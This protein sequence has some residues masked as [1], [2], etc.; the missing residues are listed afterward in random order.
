MLENNAIYFSNKQFSGSIYENSISHILLVLT[1]ID[2]D[3]RVID[4]H[5]VDIGLVC[6]SAHNKTAII[7]HFWKGKRRIVIILE[8]IKIEQGNRD[9]TKIKLKI[10]PNINITNLCDQCDVYF[11]QSF[12]FGKHTYEYDFPAVGLKS[13]PIIYWKVHDSSFFD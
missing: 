8:I 12:S 13:S 5:N 7:H 4:S 3:E 11:F 10:S 6:R 1:V 9:I 2:R